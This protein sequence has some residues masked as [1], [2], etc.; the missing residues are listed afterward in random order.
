[1]LYAHDLDTIFAYHAPDQT[2]SLR[3]QAIRSAAKEFAR[4]II[5][6]APVSAD[7]I[8]AIRKVREAMMTANAAVALKGRV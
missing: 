2:D 6:N 3:Y 8:D 7:Q 4:V 5:E 1:M